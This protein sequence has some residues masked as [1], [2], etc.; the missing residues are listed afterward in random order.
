MLQVKGLRKRLDGFVLGELDLKVE[1]GD[2][3]VLLGPSG[4]GKTLLLEMVAGFQ[5]P[6]AGRITLEG[7]DI[8]AVRIQDRQVGYLCQ[9]DTLFPHLSVRENIAYGLKR[10]RTPTEFLKD[11]VEEVARNTGAFHLLDRKVD[12]LSG[13]ERQRVALARALAMDPACLLLDEPLTGMDALLRQDILMLLRRLNRSGRTFLHVTHDHHEALAV[14]TRVAIM[15]HGRIVQ[16]GTP[17]EVVNNPCSLFAAHL[18]GI[19]NF[20]PLSRNIVQGRDGKVHVATKSG[21]RLVVPG[22][23]LPRG[24]SP[25]FL[26]LD[27]RLLTLRPR[28]VHPDPEGDKG[29]P[30]MV[31]DLVPQGDGTW[32]VTVDMGILVVALLGPGECH[33]KPGD[34]V[35][36]SWPGKAV[37]VLARKSACPG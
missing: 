19:K 26:M 4:S 11:R 32:E 3:F 6:D 21:L 20:F 30:G 37:K 17:Q 14:A 12:G 8:T 15:E 25:G 5:H 36:V 27:G 10:R 22:L 23:A 16:Q 29:Y 9:G 24:A 2:Y 1:P 35:Y 31:T 7:R 28:D 34:R 18:V 13:G 33:W